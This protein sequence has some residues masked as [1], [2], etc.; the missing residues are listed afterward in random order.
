MRF[1]VALAG[2]VLLVAGAEVEA[3]APPSADDQIAAA[4]QA[5]PEPMRDDATVY[6]HDSDMELTTLREG[7]GLLICLADDPTEEDFHV[8]CYHESL[9][10][11]MERGRELQRQGH[12]RATVDSL[13]RAEIEDGSMAF[14][15]GPTALYNV[16]GPADACDADADTVRN[17]S[18]L[19]VVFVP[20]ATAES[21][22]LP[23]R[24]DGDEPWLMD[25]GEPWAHVMIPR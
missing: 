10:A 3:Q 15:E 13:R 7:D 9:D 11:F 2:L 4:V 20:Y 22:G 6:G 19:H 8:A 5:A 12:D 24:P 17:G 16:S 18:A 1:I 25:P 23:T 21:T 14:P